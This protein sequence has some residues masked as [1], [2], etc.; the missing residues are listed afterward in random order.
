MW[1]I[2]L[3]LEEEEERDQCT[4]VSFAENLLQLVSINLSQQE[5]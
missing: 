1:C 2:E 3:E 4:E 5:I